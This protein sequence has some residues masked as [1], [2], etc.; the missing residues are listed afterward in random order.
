MINPVKESTEIHLF[1]FLQIVH[2]KNFDKVKKNL[3]L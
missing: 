1:K 3:I 2:R